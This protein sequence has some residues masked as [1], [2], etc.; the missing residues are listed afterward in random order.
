MLDL[1]NSL[2]IVENPSKIWKCAGKVKKNY[3]MYAMVERITCFLF[4]HRKDLCCLKNIVSCIIQTVLST[5]LICNA[6]I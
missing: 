6:K 3:G 4:L 5:A 2:K 1:Y